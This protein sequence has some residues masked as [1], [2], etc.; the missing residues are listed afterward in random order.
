MAGIAR[1]P[2]LTLVLFVML[3]NPPGAEPP[4]HRYEVTETH[5]GSEFKIILYSLDEVAARRASRA[6]FDRI[7]RLD[8]SFNDYQPESE[9]MKLCER[10]GGPPVAVSADLF[11]I[12]QQSKA[13]FE[14]SGGAFDVTVGP[15]VR[16]WRRSRR[17]RKLPAKE[18]L[19]RALSLV[20]SEFMTLDSKTKTVRLAKPGMKLDLGAIAKGYASDA[21]VQVLKEQGITRCLVAGAGDI[22]AGDAPPDSAGWTVGI[23]PLENPESAPDRSFTLKNGAVSTSGDT[24]RFVEIAGKRYSHIVDSKTGLG[25]IDRSSVTVVANDGVTADALATAVYALGPDRG[26]ALVENIE[27]ASA[28]VVRLEE[29]GKVTYESKRFHSLPR[30][31]KD[32]LKTDFPVVGSAHHP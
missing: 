26:L 4:L 29:K 3:Q 17:E 5:M 18:T 24:E 2:V 11:N 30:A 13:M 23:A 9:L 19:E 10:A 25:K 6:A 12:L 32:A 7:A 15:V 27:G 14:R 1:Q 20:S 8:A 21:A 22:V 31:R 28:Y 16:L